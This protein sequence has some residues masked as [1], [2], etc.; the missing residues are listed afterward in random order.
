[1]DAPVLFRFEHPWRVAEYALALPE[2][3]PCI[4]T[5]TFEQGCHTRRLRFVR[6]YPVGN[7]FRLTG[8]VGWVA[9]KDATPEQWETARV[10]VEILDDGSLIEFWADTVEELADAYANAASDLTRRGPGTNSFA[11]IE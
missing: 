5:V 8:E 6:P 3:G 1:M 11:R 9:I 2:D 7:S 10:R 4:L